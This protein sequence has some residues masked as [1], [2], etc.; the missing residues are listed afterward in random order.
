MSM[1][2]MRVTGLCVCRDASCT[3]CRSTAGAVN[4]STPQLLLFLVRQAG[5]VPDDDS[6]IG[7][8]VPALQR[9][10]RESLNDLTVRAK[11][12]RSAGGVVI[13]FA[14]YADLTNRFKVDPPK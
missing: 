12:M 6:I 14:D 9:Q 5:T 11:A 8:H 7:V 4:A 13:L 3:A 1:Q 2:P 10:Q